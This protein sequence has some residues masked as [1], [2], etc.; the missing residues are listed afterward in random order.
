MSEIPQIIEFQMT[1]FLFIALA[2][3]LV[4]SRVNQSAVIGEILV[5]L[6]VSRNIQMT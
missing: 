6:L 3:Y 2:G 4:A 5:G 1:L